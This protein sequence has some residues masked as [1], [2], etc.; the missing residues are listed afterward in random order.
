MIGWYRGEAKAIG[1]AG[2]AV[3]NPKWD[4]QDGTAM[5]E[6]SPNRG[7][8]LCQGES[9]SGASLGAAIAKSDRTFRRPCDGN[10]V[11]RRLLCAERE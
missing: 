7:A 6:V 3:W 11:Q 1:I 5:P 10:G 9:G 2:S 8:V 4:I